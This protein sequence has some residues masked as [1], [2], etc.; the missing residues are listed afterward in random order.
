[1]T[2]TDEQLQQALARA[3]SR[4][5]TEAVQLIEEELKQRSSGQTDWMDVLKSAGTG[6]SKALGDL[7]VKALAAKVG[8]GANAPIVATAGIDKEDWNK[9]PFALTTEKVDTALES[10]PWHK[11]ATKEGE[12]A[13]RIGAGASF[14]PG[15]VPAAILGG[16]GGALSKWGAEGDYSDPYS[17]M[18]LWMLP[19]T[20][21]GLLKSLFR[22][23]AAQKDAARALTSSTPEDVGAAKALTAAGAERGVRIP[24]WQA[25]PPNSPMRKLGEGLAYNPHAE[26]IQKALAEQSRAIPE[27]ASQAWVSEKA[28]PAYQA[29]QDMPVD[30]GTMQAIRDNL[31][32]VA[33]RRRMASGGRDIQGVSDVIRMFQDP[34]QGFPPPAMGT[35][36]GPFTGGSPYIPTRASVGN[37]LDLTQDLKTPAMGKDSVNASEAARLAMK[38]AI[39]RAMSKDKLFGAE[40]GPAE[41]GYG[42]AKD[43]AKVVDETRGLRGANVN[44]LMG[45]ETKTSPGSLAMVGLGTNPWW[46]IIPWVRDKLGAQA[47]R[48]L[49]A[50]LASSDFKAIEQLALENPHIENFVRIIAQ[51]MRSRG[52]TPSLGGEELIRQYS[53]VSLPTWPGVK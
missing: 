49:D 38:D 33:G 41:Q 46:A 19:T 6:Y 8:I 20:A 44:P 14:G 30:P 21:H 47:A 32:A 3:K 1:M 52:Q 13:E 11:P 4:K 5:D 48:K 43:V 29:I 16:A 15:G 25:A 37:I 28:G 39:S 17:Q 45:L 9:V 51:G 36:L 7:I 18:A 22:T 40:Y 31:V 10:L 26:E 53:P 35:G 27:G 34:V 42:A 12:Y 50:A 23:S 24:M 2:Y